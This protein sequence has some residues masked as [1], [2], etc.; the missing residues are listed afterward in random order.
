MASVLHFDV[1]C[2]Y[3]LFYL[4]FF[5]LFSLYGS[6]LKADKS[7]P[8]SFMARVY[9][10]KNLPSIVYA[11]RKFTD[12]A[13]IELE[14][15]SSISSRQ[16][17]TNWINSICPI[18]IAQKRLGKR[19]TKALRRNAV[20]NIHTE[21]PLQ[22]VEADGLSLSVGI[23]DEVDNYLGRVT[24]LFVFDAHTRCVLGYKVIVSK[25]RHPKERLSSR[26]IIIRYKSAKIVSFFFLLLTY[27]YPCISKHSHPKERLS[28]RFIMGRR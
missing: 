4:C 13:N 24:I 3:S 17:F 23:V 26:F 5:C 7:I 18:L 9:L 22:R 21:R 1:H 25:H 20:K 2:N 19:L 16:T 12:R 8:A 6:I 11:Y 14:E 28:S 27:I 15:N 10:T